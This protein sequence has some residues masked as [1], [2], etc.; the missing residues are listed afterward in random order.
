[1]ARSQ[2]CVACFLSMDVT[3]I[4]CIQSFHQVKRANE[5]RGDCFRG[6]DGFDHARWSTTQG[7]HCP[8]ISRL[9]ASARVGVGVAHLALWCFFWYCIVQRRSFSSWHTMVP[10]FHLAI[11]GKL[12]KRCCLTYSL[13]KRNMRVTHGLSFFAIQT[14]KQLQWTVLSQDYCLID[15]QCVFYNTVVFSIREMTA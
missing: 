7:A 1:M 4:Y 9:H 15:L 2:D 8:V 6:P 3:C 11:A 13:P 5:I 10:S 14:T 12:S